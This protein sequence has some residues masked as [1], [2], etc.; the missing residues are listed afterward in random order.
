MVSVTAVR[1]AARLQSES[2]QNA[3]RLGIKLLSEQDSS[4]CS[5]VSLPSPDKR[6][7]HL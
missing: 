5:S 6:A 3:Q 4:R 7:S 2:Y 1:R